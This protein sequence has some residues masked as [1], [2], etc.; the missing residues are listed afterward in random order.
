MLVRG[1][2]E[3]LS[4]IRRVYFDDARNILQIKSEFFNFDI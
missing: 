2:V 3:H 4:A 1:V